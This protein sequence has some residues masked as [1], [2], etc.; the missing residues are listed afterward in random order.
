[1]PSLRLYDVLGLK[2]AD[3]TV[4]PHQSFLFQD[5]L[6]EFLGVK[7]LKLKKMEYIGVL[8]KAQKVILP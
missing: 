2:R 8:I 5:S 7:M 1:M 6:T 3:A 4:S